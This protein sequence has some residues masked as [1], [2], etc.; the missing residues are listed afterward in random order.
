IV[1]Q[2]TGKI[3]ILR[4][5]TGAVDAVPFLQV[6]GL[7]TG[8]EQGLLGLAFAPDYSTSG[9]LYVSFTDTAG[10]SIIRRYTVSAADPNAADPATAQTVLTVPQPFSNHNGGWIAFSPKDKFLY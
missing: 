5:A 2:Q 9:L 1:E 10:T 8:N 7:S 4:L 3:R 6:S